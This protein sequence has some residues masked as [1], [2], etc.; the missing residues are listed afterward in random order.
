ML[1]DYT[2]MYTY[3]FRLELLLTDYLTNKGKLAQ[4]DQLFMEQEEKLNNSI[5]QSY[6]ACIFI[7][8]MQNHL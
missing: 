6:L 4:Y 1:I 3:T 5:I 2:Y 7:N 8:Y